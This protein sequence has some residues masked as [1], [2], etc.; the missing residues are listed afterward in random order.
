YQTDD[1]QRTFATEFAYP[2]AASLLIAN[3]GVGNTN[4]AFPDLTGSTI[5]VSG[6]FYNNGADMPAG[7]NWALNIPDNASVAGLSTGNPFGGR[8]AFVVNM[9]LQN[10]QTGPAGYLNAAEATDGGGNNERCQFARPGIANARTVSDNVLRVEF[11]IPVE[12]SNNEITAALAALAYGDGSIWA[13]S[14]ALRFDGAFIDEACT[15]STDDEGDLSVIYLQT[16]LGTW[17]T[18][19]LGTGAGAAISTDRAGVHQTYA[20]DL[21]ILK[22]VLMA[23]DGKTMNT[24]YG[25]DVAGALNPATRYTGTTDYCR[26]VLVELIAGREDH[27]NTAAMTTGDAH[28]Y[29]DLHYSEPVTV[30]TLPPGTNA[31]NIRS[32]TALSLSGWDMY[33]SGADVI[34]ERLFEYP[35]TFESDSR[36]SIAPNSLARNTA[37]TGG[38][39]HGVRVYVAGFTSGG[40]P[41]ARAWPGYLV[42]IASPVGETA[43]PY[44]DTAVTDAP[45]LQVDPSVSTGIT[46]GAVPWDTEAPDFARFLPGGVDSGYYELVSLDLNSSTY[47][48][49]LEIHIVDNP[50]S[51]SWTNSDD[52]P[53]NP[54][55][56]PVPGFTGIRDTSFNGVSGFAVSRITETPAAGFFTGFE[57]NVDNNLFNP[58][59][60]AA[61]TVANDTYFALTMTDGEFESIEE[62]HLSYDPATGFVTDLAGN[63]LVSANQILCIERTEPGFQYTL[64]SVGDTKIFVKFTEPVLGFDS[65][66]GA[67]EPVSEDYF[68]ITGTGTALNV[69]GVRIIQNI[70]GGAKDVYLDL[71]RAL[72]PADVLEYELRPAAAPFFITDRASNRMPAA[73]VQPLTNIGLGVIEPVWAA[74]ALHNDTD[75]LNPNARTP[76]LFDFDGSGRLMDTDITLQA[77]IV[78]IGP[79]QPSPALNAPVSLLYDV[80]VPSSLM[81]ANGFWLPIVIPEFNTGRNNGA[82]TLIPTA[83]DGPLRNFVI[84]GDDREVRVG[85]DV[86]FIMR[87][88]N[89]YCARL[90]DPQDPRTVAPWSFAIEDL[91]R[92]TG[93]ATILNNVINPEQDET[94]LLQYVLAKGGMVTITVF[95]LDGDVIDVIQ[96]GP[97][98]AGEYTASWDGRNRG[99]RIVARGIYFIRIVAPGVDEYRKV[100]VVR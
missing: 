98:G 12:N 68:R 58:P 63:L 85:R 80:D 77:S 16:T 67:Q 38:N 86:E 51:D 37:F 55:L 66:A 62:L 50:S 93:G 81:T 23:A 31:E 13:G 3:P 34:V 30:G 36:D 87:L 49:R 99:G 100:M 1:T 29:F 79:A 25:L 22:G 69:T 48:D 61:I 26:P 91:R 84:P 60:Q 92:Q 19:A 76:A 54:A 94:A 89:L 27:V 15:D 28:N 78:P 24:N 43:V 14:G 2:G 72:N 59:P 41:P 33:Q 20:A 21:T 56:P 82:R 57:T 32:V 95:G 5:N 64:A 44:A 47:L 88:G 18:D 4:A 8:Y 35:G 74:D 7:G 46:P 70:L 90:L 10:C 96:R 52:H 73:T 42:S 71:D 83:V 17:N 6:N 39:T 11:T 65:G 97:Q 75:P 9:T 40:A 45:G 53:E